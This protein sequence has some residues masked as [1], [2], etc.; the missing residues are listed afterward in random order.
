MR[1][2]DYAVACAAAYANRVPNSGK[3]LDKYDQVVAY[4]VNGTYSYV[5]Y[6]I[7]KTDFLIVHRGTD[8]WKDLWSASRV[9]GRTPMESL[10]YAVA[11]T[12]EQI[13]TDFPELPAAHVEI[14]GHSW[15]GA[16]ALVHGY[17]IEANAVFTFG[18]PKLFDQTKLDT[19]MIIEQITNGRDIVPKLFPWFKRVGGHIHLKGRSR[20]PFGSLRDHRM[21]E[22]I[23]QLR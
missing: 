13:D 17:L 4:D 5:A 11:P 1:L 18:A 8:Q 16:I 15:G 20:W 6:N 9:T 22:Y 14:T 10:Y 2:V 12:L 19:E 21:M 3:L 23:A 7:E